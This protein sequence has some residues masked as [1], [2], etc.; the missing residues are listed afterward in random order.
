METICPVCGNEVGSAHRCKKCFQYVH[1][2]CGVSSED[3]EAE[4]YGQS[5]IC[6]NC[7]K[8]LTGM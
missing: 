2:I 7:S 6:K 5:T 4:G 3:D 8:N 1:I